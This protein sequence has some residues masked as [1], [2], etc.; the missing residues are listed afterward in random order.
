MPNELINRSFFTGATAPVNGRI[1]HRFVPA[2]EFLNDWNDGWAA[3]VTCN[4]QSSVDRGTSIDFAEK[5]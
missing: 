4:V 1:N 5:L 3:P 2:A